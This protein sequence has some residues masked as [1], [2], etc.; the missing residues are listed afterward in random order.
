[1]PES[2]SSNVYAFSHRAP[3]R[4]EEDAQSTVP[5]AK[6]MELV[7]SCRD[8]LAHGVSTTFAERLG[9]AQENLLA[10]AD[11]SIS[12]E[13]Q[14]ICFAAKRFLEQR[15]QDLLQRFRSE[16]VRVYD[17]M[18][19]FHLQGQLQ[20][21]GAG[22]TVLPDLDD[23]ALVDNSDFE[24]DLAIEK[25]SSKATYNCSQQLTALDRRVAAILRVG[26]IGQDDNPLY[27]KTLFSAFLKACRSLDADDAFQMLLLSQF[28]H[29]TAHNLPRVYRELNRYLVENGVLPKIPVEIG[30]GVESARAE[31]TAAESVESAAADVDE[32]AP[33]D[34]AAALEE[35]A[36]IAP[37]APEEDLF[38]QLVEGLHRAYTQAA[39]VPPTG[40][41][42][43]A[44][45][46]PPGAF[47]PAGGAPGY[48]ADM[49]PFP[50]PRGQPGGMAGPVYLDPNGGAVP[51]PRTRGGAVGAVPRTQLIV[52]L[53]DLQHGQVGAM[54]GLDQS[55][56]DPSRVNVVRALR[57][58]PMLNQAQ[59]IDGVTIDVVAML[60]DVMFD[61]PQFPETL[62]P[63][64][65]KLQIPVLKVALVDKHFFSNKRHPARRL[66]DVIADSAIGW[67]HEDE[68]ALHDKIR[69]VVDTVVVSFD[70]DIDIFLDQT[71]R[72]E[73]FVAEAE[74]RGARRTD[75]IRESLEQQERSEL[76][77]ARV[78]EEIAKRAIDSSLPV[79][80]KD[81]LNR[82]WRLVL[83]QIHTTDGEQSER[84]RQA[85]VTMNDLVWS[86]EPKL[87]AD[88]RHRLLDSLPNLLDRLRGGLKGVSQE[89]QWDGV[90]SKLIDIHMKALRAEP[91]EP[92]EWTPPEPEKATGNDERIGLHSAADSA[93]Q[94]LAESA[95][96]N[97]G[98]GAHGAEAS[99]IEP[100]SGMLA[101][102]SEAL[103]ETECT[104]T[105]EIPEAR[106]AESVD[107][108]QRAVEALDIGDWVEFR[109][110]RGT[111]RALRLSWV[112]G[113]RGV[114]LFANRQGETTLT[115]PKASL[116]AQFRQGSARPMNPEPL[117]ERAVHQLLNGFRSE[118]PDRA[119]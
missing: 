51:G 107:D 10:L 12:L 85:I 101:D 29:L 8:R 110:E 99:A 9:D 87:D 97:V 98:Q 114:F 16:Y 22:T 96:S 111:R 42:P 92:R 45:Q 66:L 44:Q 88:E 55:A 25:L 91:A 49:P 27:P 37:E 53:N 20:E 115:L 23:L 43:A 32:V 77:R 4:A 1:M 69:E 17:E 7:Q 57:E 67:S 83:I 3:R 60:F 64:V 80:V 104:D 74:A 58:T 18:M 78:G 39:Q 94:A 48:F 15:G 70:N 33:E 30:G 40:Q 24:R 26:R 106:V 105:E 86:V 52:A 21:E 116:L 102:D 62:R 84:W 73:E 117:T 76:A 35:S 71:A 2:N 119:H 6:V 13:R 109:S 89:D 38:V 75:G 118:F 63:Y 56:F 68:D 90:F 108:H 34:D 81:F 31:S 103:P 79:A 19:A 82:F 11:E 54:P 72:L 112:S 59:P 46:P 100:P 50:T 65:G 41:G 95:G 36:Q 28:E 14:Q 113:M 93:P 61:D 47:V 5:P